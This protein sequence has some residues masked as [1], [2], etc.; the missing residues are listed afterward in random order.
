MKVV[1]IGAMGT[2][3]SAVCDGLS[4]KHEVVLVS[5][6]GP[7]KADLEDAA[8]LRLLFENVRVVDAL[9][10][11]AGNTAGR[12]P[13][14]EAGIEDACLVPTKTGPQRKLAQTA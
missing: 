9:V 13:L 7:V 10:S 1:V 5:R 2:I 6:R 12:R 3:G 11:C 4:T 14:A 8:T